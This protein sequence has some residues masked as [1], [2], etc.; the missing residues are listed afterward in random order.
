MNCQEHLNTSYIPKEHLIC[1][2][3]KKAS[4]TPFSSTYY[5]YTCRS[6]YVLGSAE[7][8][9]KLFAKVV[10]MLTCRLQNLVGSELFHSQFPLPFLYKLFKVHVQPLLQFCICKSDV[11]KQPTMSSAVS[12]FFF[13]F[14][15]SSPKYL[16]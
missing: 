8:Q 2:E 1:L 15:V 16:M 6:G 7:P 10:K 9:D 12:G 5:S 14:S 11:F 13:S 3:I 4:E